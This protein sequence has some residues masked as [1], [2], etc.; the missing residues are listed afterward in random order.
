MQDYDW[1]DRMA[2]LEQNQ[3]NMMQDL[4]ENKALQ[5]NYMR[6]TQNILLEIRAEQNK[7]KGFYTGLVFAMSSVGAGVAILASKFFNN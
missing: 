2:R 4:Q 6:D 3:K 5:S 1:F 7:Q